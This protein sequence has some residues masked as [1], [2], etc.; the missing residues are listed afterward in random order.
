M[1]SI[2]TQI[3]KLSGLLGTKDITPWESQFITDMLD[4]LDNTTVLTDRQV[5][6]IFKIY[7]KHFG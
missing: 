1:V 7:S 2:Q 3:K 4:F 6:I 5:E